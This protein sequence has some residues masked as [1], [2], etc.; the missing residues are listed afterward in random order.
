MDTCLLFKSS[1]VGTSLF[2]FETGIQEWINSL[3]HASHEMSNP[4]ASDYIWARFRNWLSSE[5]LKLKELCY[6]KVQ[7]NFSDKLNPF[8]D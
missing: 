2:I 4:A 8:Q 1:D 5:M 3:K 6:E 7:Q